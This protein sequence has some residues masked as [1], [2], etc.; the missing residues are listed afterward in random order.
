M[1]YISITVFRVVVIPWCW[2]LLSVIHEFDGL[3]LLILTD[4]DW[5]LLHFVLFIHCCSTFYSVIH[6]FC[7]CW[8]Q[9]LKLLICLIH[10][11]HC[12]IH[13]DFID[14]HLITILVQWLCVFSH[15]IFDLTL[16]IVFHCCSVDCLYSDWYLILLYIRYI[17][18]C[19]SLLSCDVF[20]ILC[21]FCWF[22]MLWYSHWILMLFWWLLLV[23]VCY[24]H[25]HSF[26]IS[27]LLIRLGLL[28]F[29]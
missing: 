26:S 4:V 9:M 17:V 8:C 16:D 21:L 2:A 22:I 14:L 25:W 5:Y 19:I 11:I 29:R 27:F 3:L 1:G 6:L 12:Y 7:W 10:N 24:Y 13:S 23:F 20:V 28:F 18:Y 15:S